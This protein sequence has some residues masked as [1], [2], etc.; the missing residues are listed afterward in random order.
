MFCNITTRDGLSDELI[1]LCHLKEIECFNQ[2][3]NSLNT[4]I[5]FYSILLEH[6]KDNK[7]LFFQKKKLLKYNEKVKEYNDKINNLYNELI[8]EL[9][10]LDRLYNDN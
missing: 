3:I 1:E 4:S 2:I 8:D 6:L 7:P 9:L 10:L 5:K